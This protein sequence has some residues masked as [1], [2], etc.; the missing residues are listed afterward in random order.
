MYDGVPGRRMPRRNGRL[1]VI[2][3]LALLIGAV[4]LVTPMWAGLQETAPSFVLY[5]TVGI[6]AALLGVILIVMARRQARQQ[7]LHRA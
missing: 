7:A 3:L 6:P 5:W 4:L 1:L 2:G